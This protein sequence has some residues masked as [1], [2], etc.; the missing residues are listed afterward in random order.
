MKRHWFHNLAAPSALAAVAFLGSRFEKT[1]ANAFFFL[2]IS[3][4]GEW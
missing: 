4:S 3:W 2:M 1:I